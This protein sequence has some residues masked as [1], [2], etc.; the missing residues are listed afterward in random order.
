MSG[1]NSTP[2]Q[3][4]TKSTGKPS[5]KSNPSKE[6]SKFSKLL[7]L[8]EQQGISEEEAISRLTLQDQDPAKDFY[9]TLVFASRH[10]QQCIRDKSLTEKDGY[11]SMLIRLLEVGDK[12]TKTITA[13]KLSAYPE[14]VPKEEESVPFGD[15]K[16]N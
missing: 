15:R 10:I 4:S 2:K 11:Q 6:K 8:L 14:D 9:Q 7:E 5:G 12:V 1:P 16:R 3:D 13:A